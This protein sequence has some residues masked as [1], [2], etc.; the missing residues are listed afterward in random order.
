ARLVRGSSPPS[1]LIET[2]PLS[3]FQ[4]TGCRGS[5]DLVSTYH[6]A[7]V[8]CGPPHCAGVGATVA[9]LLLGTP[10]GRRTVNT[11]PL[12]GSLVTVTSPPIMRASLREIARPRPVP[13]K[14]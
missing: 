8:A 14:R 6:V 11:E 9:S 4:V 5:T 7:S 3:E 12:P 2:S 1:D 13:P 10:P